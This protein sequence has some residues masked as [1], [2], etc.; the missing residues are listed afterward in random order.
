[1]KKFIYISGIVVVNFFVYGAIFKLQHWP[2]ASI[3][4]T[5]GLGLFCLL[6]LPL[7]FVK[8]YRG[9]DKKTKSIYIAGFIC[10]F[11]TLIGAMFKIMHWPGAG[12]FL[13]VGIPLPFLYFLPVYLVYHKRSNEKTL[14]NFLGVMFLMVYIAVFSSLLALNVSRDILSSFNTGEKDI[15]VTNDV[16][17][18]I[19]ETLSK[20]LLNDTA[21]ATESK[22]AVSQITAKSD[23][24]CNKINEIKLELV[25]A[26]EGE[27]AAAIEGN[28]INADRIVSKDESATT[29]YI[30]Y[31]SD[32]A[33]GKAIDLKQAIS[34]YHT[35]LNSLVKQDSATGKIINELLSTDDVSQSSY[36]EI[37][38]V[39]WENSYFPNGAFIIAILGDLGCVESNVRMAENAVLECYK[40]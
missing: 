32:G 20:K 22:T 18:L 2:G 12:I 9:N 26:V 27:N 28:K 15:T 6:F 14:I 11:I 17:E 40:R 3:L 19:N 30:M 13:I 38:T 5:L 1:M 4:V 25:R 36:G 37:K 8:S 29:A 23:A 16:Y 10:V 21:V 34:N 39:S 33:S 7:A 35:F 24:L 31:G